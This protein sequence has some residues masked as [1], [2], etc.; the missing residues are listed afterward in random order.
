MTISK[1][2]MIEEYII[3]N[4]EL[5]EPIEQKELYKVFSN[6][7]PITIRQTLR[8]LADNGMIIRSKNMAG[9][10]FLPNPTRVLSS[11]NMDF[12]KYIEQKYLRDSHGNV[13]GYESGFSI[14]NYLGLTNQVPSVTHIYSNNVGDRKREI[15]IDNRRFVINT[16]KIDVTSKNYKFLQILDLITNYDRYSEYPIQK[17][18]RIFENY[19]V[20]LSLSNEEIN[21]ILS[22]YPIKTQLN[23]YKM[24]VDHVIT[25]R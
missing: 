3:N 2:A 14:A 22:C 7:K 25:P 6:I 15:E 20:D 4:Y 16:P 23:Y 10:Y 24:E 17:A 13:A 5:S 11:Y 9:V 19:L 1:K 18:L 8:R 12:R 21:Q